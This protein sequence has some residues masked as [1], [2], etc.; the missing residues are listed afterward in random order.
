MNKVD[1]LVTFTVKGANCNGD[2]LAGNMPRTDSMGYGEVTDVCI[3]RKIRN[4]MQDLDKDIFVQA[5]ERTKD[6]ANSLEARYKIYFNKDNKDEEVEKSFNEKWLDVRSFGQVIT[7][8][9]RSIGIRGPVSITMAK[10][11]SPIIINSTQITRSCNGMEPKNDK[12]RSSDTMG[13]KHSVEF[14][15]YFFSGAINS[16]IAEKT[17]FNEEDKEIIKKCLKT[18]FINDTSSA[19]PDGSMEIKEIFWFEHKNEI[20]NV[21]SAKIRALLEYEDLAQADSYEDY[22][23]RLNEEKL[24]EY[25]KLGIKYSHIEGI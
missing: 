21:S 5:K 7:F 20:G 25:K 11:L 3:K 6:G 1:F 15:T 12:A 2:P 22:K 18:L 4:R 16:Y 8:D 14:G 24:E 10:S 13:T 17:G 19:R 23:I 9:K